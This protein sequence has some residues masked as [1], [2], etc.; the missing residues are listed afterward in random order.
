[1]PERPT[2]TVTFLFT[3]IGGSTKLWEQHPEAMKV[4]VARHDVILRRVVGG[5]SGYVVKTTGTVYWPPLVQ[6]MR[7]WPPRCKLSVLCWQRRGVRFAR[8]ERGWGCTLAQPRS[9]RA[10]TSAQR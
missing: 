8:F 7:A 5:H 2:G 9:G 6:L 1:V 4:A 10:T 3:D